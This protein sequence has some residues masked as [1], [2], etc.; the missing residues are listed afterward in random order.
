MNKKRIS[1]TQ[2]TNSAKPCRLN[3]LHSRTLSGPLSQNRIVRQS[4]AYFKTPT[5]PHKM[6]PYRPLYAI[7]LALPV[8]AFCS[9]RH[10]VA[11]QLDHATTGFGIVNTRDLTIGSYFVW[12]ANRNSS[13]QIIDAGTLSDSQGQTTFPVYRQGPIEKTSLRGVTGGDVSIPGIPEAKLVEI[14]TKIGNEIEVTVNGYVKSSYNGGGRGEGNILN[15]KET[16]SFRS[17]LSDAHLGKI[18]VVVTELISADSTTVTYGGISDGDGSEK[19]DLTKRKTF[20]T[21]VKLANNEV[22]SVNIFGGNT[23]NQIKGSPFVR[24]SFYKLTLD[25]S[26]ATKYSFEAADLSESQ[27]QSF[28]KELSN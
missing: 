13:S 7:F 6:S 11:F 27:K 23:L 2:G 17:G 8:I 12:D 18:F 19:V 5:I 16:L 4:H 26:G 21:S 22:I 14:K 24:F 9:C 1:C 20:S 10:N 3:R 15:H 28:I 25:S